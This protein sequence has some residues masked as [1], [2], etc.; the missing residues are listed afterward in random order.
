MPDYFIWLRY[1]SWFN[2]ANEMLI[3]NQWNT[4]KANITCNS[5]A[6]QCFTNGAQILKSLDMKT[7]YQI[8]IILIYLFKIKYS[9]FLIN[10]PTGQLTGSPHL[11]YWSDIEF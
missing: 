10:S 1:L 2:Y 4:F 11:L 3:V 7:V 8:L 6:S 5:V 9:F